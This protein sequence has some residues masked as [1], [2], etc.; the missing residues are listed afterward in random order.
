MTDF[1]PDGADQSR[2]AG[3][4]PPDAPQPGAYPPPAPQPE[5]PQ[6]GAYQAPDQDALPWPTPPAPPVASTPP[7]GATPPPLPP[8]PPA[9]PT[10]PGAAVP[11]PWPTQPT[12]PVYATPAAAPWP[13][14]PAQAPA[15]RR[16]TPIIIALVGVVAL[17]AGAGG[18][19]IGVAVSQNSSSSPSASRFVSPS[20]F[21]GGSSNGGSDG[22]SSN[23]GFGSSSGSGSSATPNIDADGIASKVSPAIVNIATTL[24]GGQQAA[25]TGMVLTSSGE[26]LTNNH[27]IN[28]ATKIQVEVGVTGK[29]YTAKV[30]GYDVAD[31]VALIK[32][33]NASGMKTISTASASSVSKNDAVVA[34]GNALGRFGNPSVVAGTVTAMHQKVTAG[35]GLDEETLSDM[36]RIAANIQPGDSGGALVD[37]SGK[38]IGMNT[39]A[40]AGSG[41]YG[42]QAGTTGF[43]I[44]INNAIKIV[45]EIRNNDTSNG[46]HIG[47]RAL[48]GVVLQ[49]SSSQNPFGDSNGGG[50][51]NGAAVSDVG[52]NTPAKDAGI[53]A[54]S[55]IT[56]VDGHSITSIDQLRSVLDQYHPGDKVSVSWTDSSGQNHRASV[57]L[58]KGAPA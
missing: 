10:A 51:S 28:G 42:Y 37:D 53:E 36:I 31:D 29:T 27:V 47:D 46:A 43:A 21:D 44:P 38:V 24:T 33:N 56:S 54:G 8:V 15:S 16:R 32:L 3:A 48:L 6:P 40:D 26:V 49:D 9:P 17:L 4:T 55:T 14:A 34:I 50:D 18:A 52:D 23:G 11:P 58:G 45:E 13:A 19:A 39:A 25:G 22:S 1:E 41:Q 7:A 12:Q 2:E 57:T 20:P 35:D 30:V 5:A